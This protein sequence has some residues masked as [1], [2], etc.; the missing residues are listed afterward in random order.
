MRVLNLYAG[1]GG[2]RSGWPLDADV[3]AVEMDGAIAEV[4][5]REYP[6]DTVI[7][8]DALSYLE[9]HFSEYDF[10]WSS[11]PC[12]S[13]GQY[14][15]NVGVLGKGFKPIMPDMT[16]YAQIIFL[17]TYHQ[18]R[19]LVENTKPYYEPLIAPS[20]VLQRHL[21]WCNFPLGNL[22]LPASDIRSK[23]ALSDFG[24]LASLVTE[25]A[26]SNKRQALRNMVDERIGSHVWTAM[27]R[28][29]TRAAL[30]SAPEGTVSSRNKGA[31]DGQN[32]R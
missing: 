4:Y 26:I 8:S 25:S 16:L 11:P 21:A 28:N 18:S 7:V 20:A 24:P 6:N 10:I 13:H 19:W 22:D 2:N 14:R 15:H 27:M 17:S 29:V 32:D 30:A 31:P 9:G 23:N 5:K 3:T 12:P 1:L